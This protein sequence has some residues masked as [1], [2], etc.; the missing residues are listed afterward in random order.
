MRESPIPQ[1]KESKLRDDYKHTTIE[2]STKE[3]G[4]NGWRER[5]GESGFHSFDDLTCKQIT[6]MA[7]WWKR[8][9]YRDKPGQL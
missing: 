2:S 3:K 5:G 9:P 1:C 4:E 8:Q 7:L 6:C